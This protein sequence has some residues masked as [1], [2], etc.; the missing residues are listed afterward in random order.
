MKIETL[1]AVLTEYR[2]KYPDTEINCYSH[3]GRITEAM[4][5]EE[6]HNSK[7]EKWSKE[8]VGDELIITVTMDTVKQRRLRL[9]SIL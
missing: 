2:D 1:I 5:E 3:Y 7:N 6:M 9:M 8:R 4:I